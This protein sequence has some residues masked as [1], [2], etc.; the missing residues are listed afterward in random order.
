MTRP[1]V[2]IAGGDLRQYYLAQ[3]LSA[4]H[5][6]YTTGLEKC[7]PV[8][9]TELSPGLLHTLAPPDTI[10]LPMPVSSEPGILNTPYS[11]AHISVEKIL[12]CA[13]SDT[14]VFGGKF[15]AQLTEQL[16]KRRL[17]CT[18]YLKSEPLAIR[19][20]AVTA[21]GA[22]GIAIES[23]P[24]TIDGAFILLL[25]YGRIGRL[26]AQKLRLLGGNVTVAARSPEARAWAQAEGCTAVEITRINPLL[27]HAELIFNTVPSEIL[28]EELLHR[29]KKE[30]LLIDLA[31]LPGGFDLLCAR[32][33]GL[34]SIRAL[35]LPGRTAPYTAASILAD[36]I[37]KT[38][39]ER[40]TAYASQ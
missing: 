13:G 5:L 16:E 39:R 25:G 11:A 10:I 19:N 8:S 33:I 15:D 30:C 2:L 34:R 40:R 14:A 27:P 28:N 36:E 26:L 24:R 3:I 31:S 7:D 21:E 23:M 32:K 29:L 12:S 37:R 17:F 6:V 20:A 4:D 22:I 9:E 35:S 38:E 18:D 1:T